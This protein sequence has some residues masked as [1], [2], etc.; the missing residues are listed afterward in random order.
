[1]SAVTAALAGAAAAERLMLDA[2]T[3]KAPTGGS[4]YDPDTQTDVDA[5]DTLFSSACKVQN[6]NLVARESEVGGRTSVTVRTELHLPMSTAPLAVGNFW[7]ITAANPVSVSQPGE[8]FR[9]LGPVDGT[10]KTAR[11][12]EVERVVS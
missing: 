2:G 5:F 7:E 8:L 1:M 9:V 4:T 12:Y 10:I 6:R 3:A 11:R